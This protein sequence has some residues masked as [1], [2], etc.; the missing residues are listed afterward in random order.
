MYPKIYFFLPWCEEESVSLLEG[1]GGAEL[2][3]LVV[4][5]QVRDLVP[6]AGRGQL[7]F[8]AKK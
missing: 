8:G 5:A 3:L 6:V 2:R 4:V 7:K 1:H